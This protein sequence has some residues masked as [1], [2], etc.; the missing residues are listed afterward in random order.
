MDN[1]NSLRIKQII[2]RLLSAISILVILSFFMINFN[3]QAYPK[4]FVFAIFIVLLDYIV[5]TISDIHDISIYRAIVSFVTCTTIIYIS[6][7]WI[8][9]LNI[10][11]LSTI[12]AS[13]MYAVIQY[14]LPN[15][16]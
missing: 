2:I 13:L 10:S 5:A 12:I 11:L 16:E 15:S 8:P 3:I 1:L 4:L 9:E 6:E 7:F 14:F